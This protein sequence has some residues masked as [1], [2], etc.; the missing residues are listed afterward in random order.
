MRSEVVGG[1]Y[2]HRLKLKKEK[3]KQRGKGALYTLSIDVTI[4]TTNSSFLCELS[5]S[6]A[7][8][9]INHTTTQHTS[10]ATPGTSLR[11]S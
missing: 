9:M 8:F 2:V 5:I 3:K 10:E 7:T 11:C 4:H 1:V 6:S